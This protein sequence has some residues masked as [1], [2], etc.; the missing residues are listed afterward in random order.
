MRNFEQLLELPNLLYLACFSRASSFLL[1]EYISSIC[2]V[3]GET[4]C[5][6]LNYP[7]P[8]PLPL[9]PR[10]PD[11]WIGKRSHL[12]YSQFAHQMQSCLLSL[13]LEPPSN[14]KWP[15]LTFTVLKCFYPDATTWA[16]YCPP[17][18]A[19]GGFEISPFR[20]VRR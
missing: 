20:Q 2:K 3:A 1:A 18:N 8:S 14:T 13:K 7:F 11:S 10:K 6:G 17:G 19:V 4:L 9:H 16:E 12:Q 15:Y 5:N